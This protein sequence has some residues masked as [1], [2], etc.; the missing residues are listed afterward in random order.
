LVRPKR[1]LIKLII[2]NL[3]FCWT[4]IYLACL[5]FTVYFL[6]EFSIFKHQLIILIFQYRVIWRNQN[7][8]LETFFD[9]WIFREWI[10]FPLIFHL[11]WYATLPKNQILI[12]FR[13]FVLT[14]VFPVRFFIILILTVVINII[15]VFFQLMNLY[16]TLKS[17]IFLL[18]YRII[19]MR[20]ADRAISIHYSSNY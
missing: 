6:F 12:I 7:L 2:L 16:T 8:L 19:I 9:Y 4:I 10:W 13:I 17:N 14:F 15:Q 11:H 3:L 1:F 18:K 5:Y 20:C